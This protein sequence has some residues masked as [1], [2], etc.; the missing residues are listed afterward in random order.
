MRDLGIIET[1]R[2]EGRCSGVTTKQ[3][4]PHPNLLPQRERR[5]I[6]KSRER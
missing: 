1:F 6:K 4:Q 3:R 2:N 5:R